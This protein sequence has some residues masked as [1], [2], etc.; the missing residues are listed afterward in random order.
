LVRGTSVGAQGPLDLHRQ[1]ARG[2]LLALGAHE[3][4]CHFID[5]HDLFD[6]L[7]GVDRLEDALV[8][9]GVELV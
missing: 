2:C 1:L 9:V 5:R 8:I 3:P 6:R 4:A 7:A